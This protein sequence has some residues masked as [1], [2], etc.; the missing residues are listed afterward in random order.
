MCLSI[1]CIELHEKPPRH[2]NLGTLLDFNIRCIGIAQRNVPHSFVARD[3][4]LGSLKGSGFVFLVMW[5]SKCF[6][7]TVGSSRNHG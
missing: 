4:C 5:K 1:S 2:Q 3:V 6:T 7:L